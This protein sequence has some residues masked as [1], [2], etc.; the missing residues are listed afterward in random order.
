MFKCRAMKIQKKS[1]IW[2]QN[3]QRTLK[4]RKKASV[5]MLA[6]KGRPNTES[7]C[8]LLSEAG[9]LVTKYMGKAKLLS[10]F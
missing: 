3:N 8:P 9:N 10:A 2:S 5:S 6:A 1:L 4:A 7:V